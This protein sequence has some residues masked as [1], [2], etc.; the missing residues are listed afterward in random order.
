LPPASAAYVDERKGK[1]EGIEMGMASTGDKGAP[2][3]R[4]NRGEEGMK[5]SKDLCV[6]SENCRDLVVKQNFPLI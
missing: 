5:F 1:Q 4:K 3:K 6:I 2:G